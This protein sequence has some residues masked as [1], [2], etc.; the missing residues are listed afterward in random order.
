MLTNENEIIEVTWLIIL[1]TDK[2]ECMIADG[3]CDHVCT[4]T[5]GSYHCSCNSG[6]QLKPNGLECEGEYQP[7]LHSFKI[8]IIIFRRKNSIGNKSNLNEN[9]RY[10]C[11]IVFFFRQ[12]ANAD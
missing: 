8:S 9:F 1:P 5:N 4:N 7:L 3:G 2:N 6:F 11:F 12:K 10:V